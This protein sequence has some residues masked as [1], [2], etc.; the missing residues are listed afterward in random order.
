MAAHHVAPAPAA[1]P[2][3]LAG[4][5]VFVYHG[6]RREDTSLESGLSRRQ[7]KYWIG[8][9]QFRGQ[10]QVAA[11]CGVRIR[12][13]SEVVDASLPAPVAVMTFD[14]GQLSDYELTFPILAEAGASAE[15]FINTASVGKPGFVSWSQLREMLAGSM[16]IQSHAHD[17]CYLTECSESEVRRQVMVSKQTIEDRLGSQVDFLAVPYGDINARVV[18]IAREAGYHAVCSSWNWPARLGCD[19]IDRTAIYDHTSPGEF[20]RLLERNPLSYGR[21]LVRAAALAVPKQIWLH[22]QRRRR[23]QAAAAS[24]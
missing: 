24:A 19:V 21:R 18:R 4:V 8:R 6:L 22:V 11:E 10:L 1:G 16:S 2:F 9:D 20:E 23:G 7:R 3:H 14:D 5:P 13:L 12:R 15:F 17:H